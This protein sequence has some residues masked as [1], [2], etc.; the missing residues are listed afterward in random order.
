MRGSET[1]PPLD[2]PPPPC[3]ELLGGPLR[4]VGLVRD[5]EM[6]G[7][8]VS[9]WVWQANGSSGSCP[10]LQYVQRTA[11]G[12]PGPQ[13]FR[14]T[15]KWSAGP[16]AKQMWSLA[17]WEGGGG[18]TCPAHA[19]RGTCPCC[20]RHPLHVVALISGQNASRIFSTRANPNGTKRVRLPGAPGIQM[21][22]PAIYHNALPPTSLP[23]LA[24]E[25]KAQ[26][27][28]MTVGMTIFWPNKWDD[29]M[30]PT[31]VG[32]IMATHLKIKESPSCV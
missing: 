20:T 19:L 31:L 11:G 24:Q 32:L 28:C 30:R 18:G 14:C 6:A 15:E 5:L 17:R 26:A 25:P 1:G 13:S 23:P 9:Q 12:I 22:A 27:H 2:D 8:R 16:T 4:W 21:N 3:A 10:R 29:H 7:V